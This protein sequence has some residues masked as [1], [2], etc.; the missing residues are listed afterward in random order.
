MTSWTV[1]Y[2]DEA[3]DD[4]ER[5]QKSTALQVKKMI[6][7]VAINP[8]PNTEGGYGKPLGN[9]RD[10]DLRNCC[11]IKLKKAGIRVVY[12]LVKVETNM[13]VIVIGARKDNEVYKVA[14]KRLANKK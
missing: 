12:K 14:A 13:T 1:S 6:D 11:K 2:L 7:R 9:L 3:F 8:L 5:L 4:L 10:V